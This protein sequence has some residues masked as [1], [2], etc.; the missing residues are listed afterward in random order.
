MKRDM[1]LVR[2]LMLKLE[3]IPLATGDNV[4]ILPDSP[5]I[6]VTGYNSDQISYHLELIEQ[7]GFL[8]PVCSRSAVGIMFHGL[9]WTGHDFLDSVRS[10]DVWVKTKEV[11]AAAGGFT[12][13]IIIMAAKTYLQNTVSNLLSN[14]PL[15]P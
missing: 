10:P 9:S 7:A 15:T 12:I 5:V 4:H 11:A 8:N 2:E 3:N 14:S 1:D 6:L 13:D